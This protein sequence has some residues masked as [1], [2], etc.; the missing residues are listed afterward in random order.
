V[1]V[2]ISR[3]I[4][5]EITLEVEDLSHSGEG[6]GRVEGAEVFVPGALPGEA[7]RV[8]VTG[9]HR[10]LG[11]A[12]LIELT[13]RSGQR[14]EPECPMADTCG[15]CSLQ[16]LDYC[17]QLDF[18]TR[19][20]R[21]AIKR[22][23][24]LDDVKVNPTLGM[25]HPWRY[26]N[27]GQFH[28][29]TES[30]P[31]AVRIGFYQPGTRELLEVEDCLLMPAFWREILAELKRELNQLWGKIASGG[32][33]FPLHHLLLRT[34]LHS[35][36]TALV[37]VLSDWD[38][39]WWRAWLEGFLERRPQDITLV[40]ENLNLHPE[41]TVLGKKT[42]VVY[43]PPRLRERIG[44]LEYLLSPA[45][46]YQVNPVQTE[47]LYR[48]ALEYAELRPSDRVFD[49]YCGA[50]TISLFLA[51]E[52]GRVIGVEAQPEAVKDAE[53]NARLNHIA[54]AD[55][56]HADAAGYLSQ[57]LKSKQPAPSVVVLD[58][59]RA[60]ARPEVLR[61]IAELGPA[62]VVYVSCDPATLARDLRILT[63][64]GFEVREVQPVD[65]FPQSGHT[66]CCCLLERS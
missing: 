39:D 54:N 65:M 60:G 20:V 66:E 15:G 63:D 4:G 62:R 8:R 16:H 36:Q 50:G 59:P 46:F 13:G 38:V 3:L 41:R 24:K 18:K 23:G 31:P 61:L 52:A 21:E 30:D 7:V 37:L 43:G 19:R 48:R 57:Y 10:G 28:L 35:R 42:R 47:V 45:S 55:F 33:T 14:R 64:S 11:R 6:V 17:A 26:R 49:L 5:Q 56:I 40:A 2:D 51:R 53:R 1:T 9:F 58:P 34:S 22:I 25:D 32:W 29:E 12:E 44:E 27:K